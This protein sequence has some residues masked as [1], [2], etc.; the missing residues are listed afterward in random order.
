MK[1]SILLGLALVFSI[2]A[3][4]QKERYTQHSPEIDTFKKVI[5]AYENQDWDALASHYADT[6][7]IM[8]N[9]LE[10]NAM[11]KA[12]LLAMHKQDAEAFNS[13]EFVNGESEYEM[14]V[15]DK[16]ET[17]VNFWGIWKGD[18]K[19]TQKTYTIP[20]HY[21]A[22]FANGKIVKEF[23]YW[24][25]SELMLDFQKIQAEQKL[26]NEETAITETQNSDN[27]L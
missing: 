2:A 9:K 5:V 3:C 7:K 22:R 12:Q 24:D 27:E 4:Q 20:A 10:K 25:L 17:W 19:P 23:G 11:T 6:A 21:T 13:W 8:Y 14:V 26:K 1:K 15:T 18:F 16:G